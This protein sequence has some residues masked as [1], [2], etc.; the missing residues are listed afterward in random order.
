MIWW[1][2]SGVSP[3]WTSPAD[4]VSMSTTPEL[5]FNSNSSAVAQ[6][7]YI[8]LD[9]ANTFDTGN[10]RTYDSSTVQTN[11]DYWN[12]SAWT[13]MPAGGLASGY[14]GNEIRYTVTSAL[15]SGTWYRRVRA[16]TLV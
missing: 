6:H 11:W 16:G 1:T 9:T 14:S 2:L 13:A 3:T 5:K 8:E 10:L 15:A 4:G 7:F 12:G